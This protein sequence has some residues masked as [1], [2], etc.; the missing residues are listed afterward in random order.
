MQTKTW[1]DFI[2]RLAHSLA[3]GVIGSIYVETSEVEEDEVDATSAP[4]FTATGD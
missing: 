4:T 2:D 3:D 1:T